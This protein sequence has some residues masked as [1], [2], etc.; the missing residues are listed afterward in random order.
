[1]LK[2]K[3]L[4]YSKRLI[5]NILSGANLSGVNLTEANLTGAD[6]KAADLTNANLTGAYLTGARISINVKNW[7]SF[8][9]VSPSPKQF[10]G[11]NITLELPEKWE[12]NMLDRNLNYLNYPDKFSLL[13]AIDSLGDDKQ[14][15]AWAL[16]L[17]KSFKK[18]DVTGIATPL[19][20][21]LD[22]LP[23]TGNEDLSAWL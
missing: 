21:V 16:E 3:Y 7:R 20:A 8:L 14:K 13:I 10:A 6:L 19:L 9:S 1:M 11:A 5:V 15:V 2:H 17:I 12:G 23:Y 18:I 22:T 4:V